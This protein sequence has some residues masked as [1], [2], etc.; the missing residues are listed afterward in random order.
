VKESAGR[1]Q[2]AGSK[3]ARS[4]DR[5]GVG[6]GAPGGCAGDP[7]A[8]WLPVRERAVGPRALVPVQAGIRWVEKSAAITRTSVPMFA[9]FLPS[10]WYAGSNFSSSY[11]CGMAK[12]TIG[13]GATRG[14]FAWDSGVNIQ[15]L[16]AVWAAR[17]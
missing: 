17:E 6:E 4:L 13:A 8:T 15:A 11:G 9:W 10:T 7:E 1:V 16:L 5:R 14:K 2:A 3:L 12:G